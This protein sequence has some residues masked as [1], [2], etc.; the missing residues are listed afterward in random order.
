MLLVFVR[1]QKKK[2]RLLYLGFVEEPKFWDKNKKLK[3][4]KIWDRGSNIY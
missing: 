1:V 2:H 4:P 3:E